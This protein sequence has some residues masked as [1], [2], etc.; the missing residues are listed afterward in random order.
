MAIHL[1]LLWREI[2]LVML[3][4][5]VSGQAAAQDLPSGTVADR[6]VVE[7]SARTLS[8]FRGSVLLKTYKVALGP[9]PKGHKEREG[10]GRTPEGIYTIDSRKRDSA[11]HR[12]LHISYPNAEDRRNAR[13]RRVSPGGDIMIHGLPNGMGATGKAHVLR[14]WTNGCIAVTNDEIEELWRVVPNRARIEIKP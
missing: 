5:A 12:A 10:D 1:A 2:V 8:V 6:I 4:A 9:N 7:K 14:D 11:F 13:R 3:A